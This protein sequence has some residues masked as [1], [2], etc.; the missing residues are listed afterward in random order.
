MGELVMLA[1]S[2]LLLALA[3]IAVNVLLEILE[4]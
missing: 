4:N 1:S 2:V 3:A